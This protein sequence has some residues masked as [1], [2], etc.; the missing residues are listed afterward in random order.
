MSLSEGSHVASDWNDRMPY[1]LGC[2]G[3]VFNIAV[4]LLI[5]INV[6]IM[7]WRIE[8]PRES[9]QRQKWQCKVMRFAPQQFVSPPPTTSTT[10]TALYC[11][12][13]VSEPL[14]F[15][16]SSLFVLCPYRFLA[17]CFV[18][19]PFS[20][21]LFCVLT[22]SSL[23]VLCFVVAFDAATRVAPLESVIGD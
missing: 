16:V 22:V 23:F 15:T 13:S 3:R 17:F 19:L 5:C 1:G 7:L 8:C 6:S 18:S 12:S 10:Y 9:G 20:R 4:D 11:V 21:F 2:F 14:S